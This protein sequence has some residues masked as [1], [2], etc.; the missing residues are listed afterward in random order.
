[1]CCYK[2]FEFNSKKKEENIE[3]RIENHHRFAQ[4]AEVHSFLRSLSWLEYFLGRYLDGPSILDW[5]R[6]SPEWYSGDNQERLEDDHPNNQGRRQSY[7]NSLPDLE[8]EPSEYIWEEILESEPSVE[9]ILESETSEYEFEEILE[10]NQSPIF[11][12]D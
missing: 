2:S 8:S 10:G 9:E 3:L 1:M 6:H 7:P 11:D 5:V 4:L 12:L